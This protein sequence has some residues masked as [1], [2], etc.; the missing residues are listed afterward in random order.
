MNETIVA[1]LQLK[2]ILRACVDG[3]FIINTDRR[4]V[5][6]SAACERITGLS[7]SNV[8]DGRCSCHQATECHDEHHRSLAGALCPGLRVLSGEVPATRQRMRL[9]RPDGTTAWVETSYSRIVGSDG[10]LPFVVGIMR[11][12]TDDRERD[13]DFGVSVDRSLSQRILSTANETRQ[14]GRTKGE[15]LDGILNKIERDEIVDALRRSGG[16]RMRAA[17]TLGIS[18][19]RL[20]RRME[21]LQIDPRSITAELNNS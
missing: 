2:D 15:S 20:Y 21:A 16:Q 3:V 19:S 4:Y 14:A 18:R 13:A 9:R 1:Q 7:R 11:D 10:N 5:E 8:V 12:V 17:R 6:F